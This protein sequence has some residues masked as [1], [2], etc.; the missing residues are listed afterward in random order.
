MEAAE[1]KGVVV[2]F[3][4]RASR[5][6]VQPDMPDYRNGGPDERSRTEN[7]NAVQS[8][9][10]GEDNKV[11]VERSGWEAEIACQVRRERC[12][13]VVLTPQSVPTQADA[14]YERQETE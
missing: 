5:I 3:R 9:H 2:V 13:E 14:M 10:R 11:A 6:A 1:L 12:G 4:L 7:E 8:S